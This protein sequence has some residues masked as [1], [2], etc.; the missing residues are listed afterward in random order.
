MKNS[1]IITVFLSLSAIV[2]LYVGGS[3]LFSPAALQ[4]QSDIIIESPSHFSE[5]RAPG[6]AIFFSTFFII[7]GIFKSNWRSNALFLSALLFNAYGLGRLLSYFLDGKPADG[8]VAAMIGELFFGV[9][10][11]FLY[12]KIKKEKVFDKE[13]IMK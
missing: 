4:A 7:L 3:L 1:T 2:G 10:A 8:L 6:A 12:I 9:I 5:T 11:L 13:L